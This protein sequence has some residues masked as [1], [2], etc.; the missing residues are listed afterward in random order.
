M[1]MFLI[2]GCIR[3]GHKVFSLEKR[4]VADTAENAVKAFKKDYPSTKMI[5]TKVLKNKF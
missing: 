3:C 2:T 5:R 4:I 1:K